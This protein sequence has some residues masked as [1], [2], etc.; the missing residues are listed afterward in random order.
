MVGGQRFLS[1]E[2]SLCWQMVE[3][4]RQYL[5]AP[6]KQMD[7]SRQYLGCEPRH[8]GEEGERVCS[9]GK[10]CYWAQLAGCVG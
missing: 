6:G 10:S 1:S 7:L 8:S 4:V 9:N 5:V 3:I 2:Q